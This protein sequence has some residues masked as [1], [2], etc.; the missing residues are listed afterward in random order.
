MYDEPSVVTALMKFKEIDKFSAAAWEHRGLIPSDIDVCNRLQE[1]F[2]D[3]A[4]NLAAAIRQGAKKTQLKK[5][6][7]E[8]LKKINRADYDT[9]EREFIC[10]YFIEL[11]S[12]LSIDL[13]DTINSWLY[14][15]FLA[16][17]IKA[18]A[19]FKGADRVIETLHQQCTDC[20]IQ[21]E[22]LILRKEKGIPDSVW[23]IIQCNSC[24]GYN[25][26]SIG[27][28]IKKLRFGNYQ[29]I[30]ELLK[31]DYT[32]EQAKTRLEQ[33]RYFRGQRK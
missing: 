3:C 24:N 29:S 9:E 13:R 20:G 22:T 30:E 31:T 10:Y 11:S 25:L 23:T 2:N 12:V 26:L 19:F 27:P 4:D 8:G 6:L 7:T 33:I 32:E 5:L 14:G 15:S 1:A 21:L 16:V 18:A 17:V 28:N